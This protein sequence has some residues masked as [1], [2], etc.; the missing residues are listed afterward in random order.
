MSE[1]HLKQSRFNYSAYRVFTKN[2]NKN[3]KI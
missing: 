3:S 2:K 1:M